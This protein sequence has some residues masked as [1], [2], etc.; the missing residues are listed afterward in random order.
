MWSA[1][2]GALRA[3]AGGTPLSGQALI[4]ELGQRKLLSIDQAH[5]LVAFLAVRE[6]LANTSYQ[7]T[8]ADIDAARA[9]FGTLDQ[10]L[11]A[12]PV[13]AAAAPS[14]AQAAGAGTP[15]ATQAVTAQMYAPPPLTPSS[16]QDSAAPSASDVAS[17]PFAPAP[18]GGGVGRAIVMVLL[19]V[20][21]VAGGWYYYAAHTGVPTEVRSGIAAY[22]AGQREAARSAFEHA[23]R[24]Y[25]K[26]ALPHL[27]LAR[28]AR[29]DG[30][31]AAAGAELK[32]AVELDPA[33]AEAQRE[34]GSLFLARGSHFDREA[35]ADLALADYDAARRSYVRALQIDPTD[36]SA[37]GF[38]G[39]ALTRLGRAQEAQRW[40][41]RAGDG[42]WS[43]CAAPAAANPAGA[44]ATRR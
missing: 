37:Q 40:F 43:T 20:V 13:S 34:L 36:R 18:A 30:D 42:P 35:R 10:P 16:P 1:I 24:D 25:P 6:K 23:V 39:C 17:G 2:E 29:E 41:A 14:F 11:S 4:G 38:L 32:T 8:A 21:I 22:T 3:L 9:A 33:S 5:A 31:F 19:L 12:S 44:P 26:L 27:Y 28:I 15:A 7:P